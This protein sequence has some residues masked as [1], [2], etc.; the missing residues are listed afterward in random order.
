MA[1][2]AVISRGRA[3]KENEENKIRARGIEEQAIRKKLQKDLIQNS[4]V[5]AGEA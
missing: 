3:S 4:G 2:V 1:W 5:T